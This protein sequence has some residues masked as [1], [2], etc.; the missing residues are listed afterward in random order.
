MSVNLFNLFHDTGLFLC[1]LKTL[2][3]NGFLMFSGD[4][5]RN[6]WHEVG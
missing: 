4:I 3:K 1:S 6:Q 2:E 5:E